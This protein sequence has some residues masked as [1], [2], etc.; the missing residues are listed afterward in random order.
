MKNSILK[1]IVSFAIAFVV[2]FT[3]GCNDT[4]SVID[5]TKEI[6]EVAATIPAVVENDL[7]LPN[8]DGAITIEWFSSNPDVLSNTGK[9]N[10]GNEDVVVNLTIKMSYSGQIKEKTVSVKVPKKAG[11]VDQTGKEYTV[12]FVDKDG[13]EISSQKLK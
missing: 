8:S 12:K 7:V 5:L 13:K 3:I 4:P 9:V 1:R 2:L 10:R 6:E 11:T